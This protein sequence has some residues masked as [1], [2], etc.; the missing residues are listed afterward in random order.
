VNQN[1]LGRRDVTIRVQAQPNDRYATL[2]DDDHP[3]LGGNAVDSSRRGSTW[4]LQ[5][6]VTLQL[7]QLS[8]RQELTYELACAPIGPVAELAANQS[9]ASCQHERHHAQA[10][11]YQR[12]RHRTASS[13]ADHLRDQQRLVGK[14]IEGL[15]SLRRNAWLDSKR[16]CASSSLVRED[17]L[18]FAN[19]GFSLRIANFQVRGAPG[20]VSISAAVQHTQGCHEQ[21][22]I[23]N[24]GYAPATVGPRI[25]VG[26]TS[27]IPG[28]HSRPIGAVH[29]SASRTSVLALASQMPRDASKDEHRT[30]E[31]PA[32]TAEGEV[33]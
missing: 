11:E 1:V 32:L 2:H 9:R 10:D 6:R 12:V 18:G 19:R 16:D 13:A 14:G 31:E 4:D 28:Q 20:D 15:D 26:H 23:I 5:I 29:R 7:L 33:L 3:W 27:T 8:R 30:R 22:S 21:A 25:D 24:S 17:A